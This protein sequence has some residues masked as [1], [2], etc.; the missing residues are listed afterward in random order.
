MPI[1]ISITRTIALVIALCK[2]HNF[3]IDAATAHQESSAVMER[4]SVAS[5]AASD[6][7]KISA[8]GGIPLETVEGNLT[9]PSQLLDGNNRLTKDYDRAAIAREERQI[10]ALNTV[11]PRERLLRII[12][13]NNYQRVVP[14]HWV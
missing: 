10:R 3:C 2:L 11:L 6:E 4:S 7:F 13:E 9:R 14:R 12:E 8:R 1:N 5:V